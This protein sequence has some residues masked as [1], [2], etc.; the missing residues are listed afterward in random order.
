MGSYGERKRRRG[1]GII[2]MTLCTTE[3]FTLPNIPSDDGHASH[4]LLEF[5]EKLGWIPETHE[6]VPTKILLN[7]KDHKELYGH[8]IDNGRSEDEK[9]GLAYLL[10]CKGPSSDSG[11]PVGEVRLI[12][13]WII[14]G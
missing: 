7:D 4:M 10:V 11:V 13:G 14:E 9:T 12:E 1:G 2:I 5:Y 8:I 3:L 6:L